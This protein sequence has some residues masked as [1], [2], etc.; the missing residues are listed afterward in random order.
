MLH[1]RKYV[2]CLGEFAIESLE[3]CFKGRIIYYHDL[4]GEGK[5]AA[6][7]MKSIYLSIQYNLQQ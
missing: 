2:L 7:V 5:I 6:Y 4:P 3:A 1:I